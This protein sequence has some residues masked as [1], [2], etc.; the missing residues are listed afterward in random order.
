[1]FYDS[2]E[3]GEVVEVLHGGLHRYR[4]VDPIVSSRKRRVEKALAYRL[5]VFETY[6]VHRN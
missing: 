4:F 5:I 6:V 1:M 3:K 2:G